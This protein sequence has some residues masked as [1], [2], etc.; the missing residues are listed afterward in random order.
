M[1]EVYS[2]GAAALAAGKEL[3]ATIESAAEKRDKAFQD[4]DVKYNLTSTMEET[5]SDTLQPVYRQAAQAALN[6]AQ[7]AAT[8]L[9]ADPNNADLRARVRAAQRQY[10]EIK[11]IGVAR[12]AQDNKTRQMIRNGEI[13]DMAG[14]I[15]EN[16]AKM[17]E[18]SS[19]NG[20]T[21]TMEGGTVMITNPD[22]SKTPML[23]SAYGDVQGVFT[24]AVMSPASKYNPSLVG[25]KMNYKKY[26]LTDGDGTIGMNME[27][28][29]GGFA[30]DLDVI[31]RANPEAYRTAV[32]QNYLVQT[33]GRT[34]ISK[35]ELDAEVARIEPLIESTTFK[36]DGKQVAATTYS[37]D[38]DGKVIYDLSDADIVKLFEEG[39][40]S[41]DDMEALKHY[42]EA[43]A[44]YVGDTYAAEANSIDLTDEIQKRDARI[45]TRSRQLSDTERA[46]QRSLEQSESSLPNLNFTNNNDGTYSVDGLTRTR[47][48]IPQDI[49]DDV[50]ALGTLMG[51]ADDKPI[52]VVGGT[53]DS[54]TGRFVSVKMPAPDGFGGPHLEVD[55]E[56]IAAEIAKS[57]GSGSAGDYMGEAQ[58]I[59][60]SLGAAIN[61]SSD[62]KSFAKGQTLDIIEGSFRSALGTPPSQSDSGGESGD[63]LEGL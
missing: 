60:N 24:P 8:A 12:T 43:N 28:L 36:I 41:K 49:V 34:G 54:S 45:L 57:R 27:A 21:V 16:L 18:M 31:R 10:D 51:G 29:R 50:P 38:E 56:F 15:E 14:S 11:N 2:I 6:E 33:K 58:E 13:E 61:N 47:V 5:V 1:A 25:T 32:A 44:M 7:E 40:I 53:L 17:D 62:P 46:Y 35:Q 52:A 30:E 26:K 4:F 23:G 42:R 19:M 55:Q 63:E 20:K 37:L 22:G 59:L 9:E 48:I 39:G 3:G